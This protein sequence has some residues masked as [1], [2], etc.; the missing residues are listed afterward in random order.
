[1]GGDRR[2][3]QPG[4]LARPVADALVTGGAGFIGSHLADALLADGHTV[5]VLDDM[6]TGTFERLPCGITKLHTIDVADTAPVNEVIA[7]EHPDVVFHLAA[8]ISVRNSVADPQ[9]DAVDNILGSLNVLE[10]ARAVGARVVLASTGGALYGDGVALPTPESVLPQTPAPYG[11]SKYCAEQY[12]Q[13]SN[14]LHHTRHVALRLGNVYG[15]R[16]DPHGEAGVVAIFC[17]RIAADAEPVVFADGRQT[18]DYVYVGDVVEAFLAAASYRGPRSVFNIGTGHPTTVWDL[19]QAVNAAAG[20]QIPARSAPPRMG[21]WRHG[22]LD[23]S[24]AATELGWRAR[25]SLVDGIA[26]TYKELTS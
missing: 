15:P 25:T 6:S 7:E 3:D 10:A 21:E 19:L 11:I 5:S 12:L 16:Q 24:L 26:A 14:R 9:A 22:A 18:R 17:G 2:Q 23:S 20:K 13:L 4:G 1:M 8:Q